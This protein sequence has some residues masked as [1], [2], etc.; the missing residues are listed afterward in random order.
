MDFEVRSRQVSKE[1]AVAL[2]ELRPVIS[3]V[4]QSQEVLQLGGS[5]LHLAQIR[6]LSGGQRPYTGGTHIELNLR[7]TTP[8]EE[9]DYCL[10]QG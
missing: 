6:R 1:A 2:R 7:R 9:G 5:K 4:W 10:D 8:N 3:A